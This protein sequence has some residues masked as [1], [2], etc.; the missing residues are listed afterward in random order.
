VAV[1][2]LTA[3]IHQTGLRVVRLTAKSRE[4]IDSD[5]S[6]LSLHEQVANGRTSKELQDALY[7]EDGLP[8]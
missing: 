2:H 5:V 8:V 3:K 6:F 1:D 7:D 4:A